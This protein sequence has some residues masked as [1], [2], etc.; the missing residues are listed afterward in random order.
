[1][2][3][4][5]RCGEC[6]RAQYPARAFCGFCLSD[7]IAWESADAMTA[8]VV[9][10]TVLY[11]SNEPAFRDRLP[12]PLGLVQFAAGPVAV[13]FLAEAVK[14]GDDVVVRLDADGLLEATNPG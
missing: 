6:G 14:A 9:A 8:R 4:L 5:Q 11:H 10:R 12:R 2:M 13:C 3:R 1:M 7:R